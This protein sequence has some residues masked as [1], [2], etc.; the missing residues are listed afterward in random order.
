MSEND[1]YSKKEPSMYDV[2]ACITKYEPGTFED[3][4]YDYGYDTDSRKAEKTYNAVC[5]EYK[6]FSRL[7]PEGIPDDI[8]DIS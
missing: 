8:I 5:K 7:F 2:L 6:G 3:F 1:A 4:C